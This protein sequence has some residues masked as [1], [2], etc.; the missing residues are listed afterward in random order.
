MEE[1]KNLIPENENEIIETAAEIKE[2]EVVSEHSDEE[3]VEA[4]TEN[5]SQKAP[6]A[7]KN[8]KPKLL[9]N[10]F[11]LKHGGY[12]LAIT[13]AVLA[14]LIVINI[15]VS[16]L[17]NRFN[18]DFD[19]STQKTNTMSKENIEFIKKVE[20]EVEITFCADKD[21]YATGE[22]SY[23]SQQYGVTADASEYYDQT[24][25]LVEKYTGY[26]K[27]I[28]LK[29]V[30]V[31]SSEF[32]AISTK[33][34]TDNIGYGDIIVSHSEGEIE[35]HRVVGF[36]D[37][38]ELTEEDEYGYGYATSTTV[39][40]NNIETA[41]TS[42][43]AYVTSSKTKKLAIIT[44]H[45]KNDYSQEFVEILEKN[46]YEVE[47]IK[48]T[49]VTEISDEFD[50]VLIASPTTDFIDA[51]IDALS[52]FL[53]ND[54]KLNKGLMFFADT[55]S[56]NLPNIYDFLSQWG[57][58]VEEGILFETNTSNH[59]SDE[60]MSMGSYETDSEDEITAG[61]N[62]CLTGYNV[63]LKPIFESE[64]GI[65][66]SVLIATPESV[67]AAPIGTT[68]DWAGAD[69]YE[70]ASYPT[71]VQSVKETYDENNELISSYVV[72]FS[73]AEF[74]YSP[75]NS[76]SSVSNRD[77]TLAVSERLVRADK[78]GISFTS[79]KISNESFSEQVTEAASKTVTWIFMGIIPVLIV[80]V[81]I[82]IFIK[83]RN[84]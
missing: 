5:K 40:G 12:S 36:E 21:T 73:S 31:Q 50:A 3:V 23:Y 58:K 34:T 13:A 59:M 76:Q 16:A 8:K 68:N 9:K 81:G 25:K 33:Y 2:T 26:N 74:L 52:E 10:Q 41:L 53:D 60:P 44:G 38:Y 54:G 4:L 37:I 61:M 80:A 29:F 6:K 18:L 20:K 67:V 78:L 42:A 51:E 56:P 83:R 45:S 28:D 55:E 7:K 27:N 64:G 77:I 15:L 62:F 32:S 65:T 84:A 79:K 70:K 11:A 49:L 19:M 39:S 82:Y 48:D 57:V 66:V 30:D 46:N 47:V 43:I 71:V 35:K 1:N 22:M 72:T 63:P 24:L 75:F 69:Q 17:S 14:G